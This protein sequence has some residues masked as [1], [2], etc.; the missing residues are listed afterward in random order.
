[1][2]K[3]LY[4]VT[5]HYADRADVTRH[6]QSLTAAKAWRTQ[7]LEGY[8]GEYHGEDY[9]RDPIPPAMA[10]TLERSAPISFSVLE[11]E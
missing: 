9:G 10:V 7:R 3:Y 1:M 2:T 6:Y 5:A 4:R 11:N 8:P